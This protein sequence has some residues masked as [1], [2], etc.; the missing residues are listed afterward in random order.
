VH[1]LQH[2]RQ[3]NW[4]SDDGSDCH[5]GVFRMYNFPTLRSHSYSSVASDRDSTSPLSKILFRDGEV[6]PLPVWDD[7]DEPFWTK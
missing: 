2:E 5:Q 4:Y 7:Y 6:V 3:T 1:L